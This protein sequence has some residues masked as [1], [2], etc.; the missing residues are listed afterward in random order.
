VDAAP[1]RD[2][3]ILVERADV[4]RRNRGRLAWQ[5]VGVNGAG[6]LDSRID[7]LLRGATWNRSSMALLSHGT[8]R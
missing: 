3:E 7:R 4:V 8:D 1:R 5:A 6:L 2:A